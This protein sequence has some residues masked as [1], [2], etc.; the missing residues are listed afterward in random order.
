MKTRRMG[1]DETERK[2][3]KFTTGMASDAVASKSQMIPLRTD[4]TL[5]SCEDDNQRGLPLPHLCPKYA[6]Q[7]KHASISAQTDQAKEHDEKQDY[8]GNKV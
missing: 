2:M 8:V 1:K 6:C 5:V 4:I 3:Y 7:T